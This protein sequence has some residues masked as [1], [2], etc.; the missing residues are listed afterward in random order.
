MSPVCRLTV[1][2]CACLFMFTEIQ[3]NEHLL[4][5][6]L[7]TSQAMSALYMHGLSQGN[8]KYSKEFEQYKK[9]SWTALKQYSHTGKH[10]DFM[11]QWQNVINDLKFHYDKNNGW[12]IDLGT[13]LKFR[14]YL[15]DVYQEIAQNTPYYTSSRLQKMLAL[16]QLEA[17]SARF[18]DI[19][20]TF[21]G[22]YSLA[23]DDINKLNPSLINMKFK[24]NLNE[25]INTSEDKALQKKLKR[26][27][28]K[29]QFI[30]SGVIN[31]DNMSANFLVYATKNSISKTLSTSLY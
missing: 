4:K 7:F 6:A 16:V 23:L 12:I 17:I 2:L 11:G 19:S 15:S 13:R 18:F 26:A 9:Q 5:H 29:W 27:L 8:E 10:H 24:N 22:T 21:S 28:S 14:S 31:Y 20:S 25:Q 1:T 30:E 3:A